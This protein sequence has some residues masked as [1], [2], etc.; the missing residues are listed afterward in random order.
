[1]DNYLYYMAKEEIGCVDIANGEPVW[2]QDFN[3]EAD[4]VLSKHEYR[5]AYPVADEKTL[6]ITNGPNVWRVDREAGNRLQPI[7]GYDVSLPP[8]IPWGDIKKVY[9]TDDRLYLSRMPGTLDCYGR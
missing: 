4:K 2:T 3:L 1:M 6:Y 8:C 7:I 9:A 5:N